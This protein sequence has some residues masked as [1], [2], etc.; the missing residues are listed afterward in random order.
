MLEAYF[1][2]S[3]IHV[4]ETVETERDCMDK[5]IRGLGRLRETKGDCKVS[6]NAELRAVLE[7]QSP[8]VSISLLSLR[9]TG[10]D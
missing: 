6:G 4:L 3:S 7:P 2:V 9:Q 8:S 1:A 10:R 5:G